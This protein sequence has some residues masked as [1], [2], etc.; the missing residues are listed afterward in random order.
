MRLDGRAYLT[1]FFRFLISEKTLAKN[2]K[3][4]QL[5]KKDR[6]QNSKNKQAFIQPREKDW[7][8]EA[9]RKA[10]AVCSGVVA[11]VGICGLR[12]HP[13]C[14]QLWHINLLWSS[15]KTVIIKETARAYSVC[16]FKYKWMKLFH[17]LICTVRLCIELIR[18]L[19][20]TISELKLKIIELAKA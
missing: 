7:T 2:E 11:G 12:A 16:S 5:S 9:H 6:T 4:I 19:V 8:K 14:G 1:I 10:K 20:E 3:F 18:S 13:Y 15:E 17:S